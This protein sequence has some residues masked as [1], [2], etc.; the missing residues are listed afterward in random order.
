MNSSSSRLVLVRML[1][2]CKPCAESCANTPFNP[3]PFATST[4]ISRALRKRTA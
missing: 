2:T 4:S 1:D 3:C